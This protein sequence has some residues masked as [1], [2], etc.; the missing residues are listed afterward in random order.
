M[1]S[2]AQ[3]SGDD[4]ESPR[5][6]RPEWPPQWERAVL[7]QLNLEY[8]H[9]IT[10]HR[11]KLRPAL[12]VLTESEAHWGQWNR[13]SRTISISKKLIREHQWFHVI[14]ILKHEMA[15]Q[16]VDEAANEFSR[17][18]GSASGPHGIDFK[19]ACERLGVPAHYSRATINLQ[20]FNLDWREEIHDEVTEKMLEKT[21]KLLALAAS[22]NENE[23]A[24][25]M[26]R[27]RDIYANSTL[28]NV[29]HTERSFVHLMIQTGTTKVTVF[30][31][32]IVSILVGHFFVEAILMS[33]FNIQRDRQERVIELI[34]RRENIL[35]AEYVYH[36]LMAQ[37]RD[38]VE[39]MARTQGGIS[40]VTRRS[41][42]MGILRGFDEKLRMAER[43]VAQ[44]ATVIGNALIAFQT[45]RELADYI[46][47]VHPRL[48]K[49]RSGSQ[50]IDSD[51][52]AKG[53]KAGEQISLHKPVSNSPTHSGR[54]LTGR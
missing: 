33:E 48:T 9:T 41:F 10:L 52:Y 31:R 15:H 54:A 42:R 50:Q 39:K 28:E 20:E 46:K 21:R 53:R 37:S 17:S 27:V 18:T 13:M 22:T 34:G 36:F 51:A 1:N 45:D 25:A 49:S 26:N 8:R 14:G 7:N 3:N 35:M 4:R 29:A 38:L 32:M 47:Q 23:A 44:G 16:L 24:L 30:D 40:Q 11:V 6:T 12:I 19:K 5:N 43:P 2:N